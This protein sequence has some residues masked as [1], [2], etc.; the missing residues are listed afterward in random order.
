MCLA[1]PARITR[2]LGQH[3]A[4]VEVGGL[5]KE[6]SIDLVEP[7]A[8]G[9]YV[10]VHTGFALC[11]IRETEAEQTLGYFAELARAQDEDA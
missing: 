1:I 5:E 6:I 4:L 11:R 7:V 9:E 2:L 8:L 3:R 10:V